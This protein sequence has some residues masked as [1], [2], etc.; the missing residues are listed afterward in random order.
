MASGLP[1]VAPDVGDIRLVVAPENQ[2]LITTNNEE[3][4]AEALLRLLDDAGLRRR[5]GIANRLRA[6]RDFSQEAM[7]QAYQRLFD[8]VNRHA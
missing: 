2:P 1:V 6:S 5:V 3:A 7:F 8:P 4:L